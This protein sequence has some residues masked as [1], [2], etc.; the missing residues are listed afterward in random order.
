MFLP[1]ISRIRRERIKTWSPK[2]IT[3][4]QGHFLQYDPEKTFQDIHAQT[5]GEEGKEISLV[6]NQSGHHLISNRVVNDLL[7]SSNI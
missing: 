2:D 3:E 5:R 4:T 1:N 7:S 6:E